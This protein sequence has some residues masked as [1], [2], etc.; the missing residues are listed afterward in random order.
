M[1]SQ[2]DDPGAAAELSGSWRKANS[3]FQVDGKDE[4]IKPSPSG[5]VESPK[6]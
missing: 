1:R 6:Q 3:E 2:H 4:A 5:V